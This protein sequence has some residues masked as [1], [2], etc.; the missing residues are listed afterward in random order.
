MSHPFADTTRQRND[1]ADA[2]AAPLEYNPVGESMRMCAYCATR[3]AGCDRPLADAKVQGHIAGKTIRRVIV[4]P[5]KLA[6]IVTS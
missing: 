1:A 6:N 4:V 2:P 5:G 3:A